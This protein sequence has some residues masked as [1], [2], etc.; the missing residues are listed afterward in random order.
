M[1]EHVTAA[2][3]TVDLEDLRSAMAK[4]CADHLTE[5]ERTAILLAAGAP[6]KIDHETRRMIFCEHAIQKDTDGLWRVAVQHP[7]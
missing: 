2:Q 5:R 3:P 4:A 1:T 6:F 7:T